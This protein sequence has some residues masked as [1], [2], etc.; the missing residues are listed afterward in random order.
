MSVK[1]IIVHTPFKLNFPVD[2]KDT[3]VDF[4]A[5]VHNVH[6]EVA[7]HWYVRA[8]ANVVATEEAVDEAAEVSPEPEAAPDEGAAEGAAETTADTKPRGGRRK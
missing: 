6:A 4:D 8:H 2:G 3:L 5:G 1:Q 7:D